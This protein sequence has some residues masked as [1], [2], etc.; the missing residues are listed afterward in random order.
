MIANDQL[1]YMQEDNIRGAGVFNL[2]ICDVNTAVM[3]YLK[4][5][6]SKKPLYFPCETE[7]DLGM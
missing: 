4:Y 6:T 3:N 5:R 7:H 1:E 2:P